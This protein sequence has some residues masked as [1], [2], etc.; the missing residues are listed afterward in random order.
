MTKKPAED[1][2]SRPT[3]ITFQLSSGPVTSAFAE[4]EVLP[5]LGQLIDKAHAA[6]LT[7]EQFVDAVLNVHGELLASILGAEA[8]GN[9]MKDFGEHLKSRKADA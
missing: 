1:L 9:L 2:I 3:G 7:N 5:A 6:E 8:A 4:R